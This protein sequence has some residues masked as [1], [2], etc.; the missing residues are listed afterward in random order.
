MHNSRA[1]THQSNH[2]PT[3]SRAALSGLGLMHIH[4]LRGPTRGKGGKGGGGGEEGAPRLARGGGFPSTS[5][6]VWTT[7]EQLSPGMLCNG[8]L[9]WLL[10]RPRVCN[11]SDLC[12][13]HER[14]RNL[15]TIHG[16]RW[17]SLRSAPNVVLNIT[18]ILRWP[19]LP[20]LFEPASRARQHGHSAVNGHRR[21]H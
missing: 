7:R 5:D 20:A 10:T 6:S 4:M 17:R 12:T 14:E 3:P 19:Q 2:N 13:Q 1:V 9:K 11:Q 18:S 15:A 21:T 8:S 16:G